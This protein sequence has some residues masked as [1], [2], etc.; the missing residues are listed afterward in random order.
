MKKS[1]LKYLFLF[2]PLTMLVSSCANSTVNDPS[3]ITKAAGDAAVDAAT[4]NTDP[5]TGAVIRQSTGYGTDPIEKATTN[6]LGGLG[7]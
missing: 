6:A 4:E 2:T 3:G 5:L 7:L 1:F